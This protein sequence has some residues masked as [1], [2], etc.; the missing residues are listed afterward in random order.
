MVFF[1][2]LPDVCGDV[3]VPKLL[4]AISLMKTLWKILHTSHLKYMLNRRTEPKFSPI[5]SPSQRT[6]LYSTNTHGT[7]T[8]QLVLSF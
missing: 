8:V 5:P 7:L 1:N 4:G 2:S 3:L 6:P